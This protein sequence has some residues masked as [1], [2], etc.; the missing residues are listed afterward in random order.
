[1]KW[2]SKKIKERRVELKLSQMRTAKAV[3]IS[4]R[5][6][7]DFENGGDIKASNLQKLCTYLAVTIT[8]Q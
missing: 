5:S 4:R 1:M 3:G 8:F 7:I 6:L 2:L